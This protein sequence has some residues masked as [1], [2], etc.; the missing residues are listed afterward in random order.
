MKKICLLFV[1]V[2]SLTIGDEGDSIK[3]W[4]QYGA[5]ASTI[6]VNAVTIRKIYSYS[7]LQ[8]AYYKE[9]VEKTQFQKEQKSHDE[10]K[11]AAKNQL[12]SCLLNNYDKPR[13]FLNFPECCQNVAQNYGN[14]AG[15]S[16]LNEIKNDFETL[17]Q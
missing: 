13:G 5:Y 7:Q 11:L 9:Q 8:D 4:L 17:T 3:K 2:T 6:I 1:S 10:Q 14:I 15:L 12:Q 16:A